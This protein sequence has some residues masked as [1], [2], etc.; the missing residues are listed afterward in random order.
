MPFRRPVL[1]L[2]EPYDVVGVPVVTATGLSYQPRI[3]TA[4]E[5]YR[6]TRLPLGSAAV[7]GLRAALAGVERAAA[8]PS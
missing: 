5:P 7:G 4:V 2:L 8:R 6:V 1:S 3:A